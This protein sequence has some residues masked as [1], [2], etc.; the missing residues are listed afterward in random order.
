MAPHTFYVDL[1][2]LFAQYERQFTSDGRRIARRIQYHDLE[3]GAHPTVSTRE[4]QDLIVAVE[5]MLICTIGKDETGAL[6]VD[7][8]RLKELLSTLNAFTGSVSE[9]HRDLEE[10][11]MNKEEDEDDE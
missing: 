11:M 9:A 8:A 5:L 3:L 2:V 7:E 1:A 10:R 6:I 4:L